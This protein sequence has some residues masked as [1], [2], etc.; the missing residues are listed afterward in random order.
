MRC[1]SAAF[2]GTGEQRLTLPEFF[3][4][5]KRAEHLGDARRVIEINTRSTRNLDEHGASGDSELVGDM[6]RA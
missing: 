3:Q 4:Q 2:V 6:Q 5:C 1:R